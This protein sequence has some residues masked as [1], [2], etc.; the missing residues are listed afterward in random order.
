MRYDTVFLDV[1]GTL[2]WMDVDV[3]GYVAD[4]L[5]YSSDPL[6]GERAAGP[7]W[8]SVERHVFENINYPTAEKLAVVDRFGNIEAPEAG[9]VPVD[10]SELPGLIAGRG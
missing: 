9:A 4:L 6:T 10:L 2:L 7:V 5:P 8:G 1:D 3:E